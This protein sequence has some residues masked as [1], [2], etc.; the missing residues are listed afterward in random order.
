MFQA[1]LCAM[2]VVLVAAVTACAPAASAAKLGFD[3][4]ATPQTIRA[5]AERDAPAICTAAYKVLPAD[6]HGPTDVESFDS[7]KERD[8]GKLTEVPIHAKP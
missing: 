6:T 1:N 2:S 3:T 4:K 7:L 5:H 8:D